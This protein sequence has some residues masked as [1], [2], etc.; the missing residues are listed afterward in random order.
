[1]NF[2][3]L[4]SHG[5]RSVAVFGETVLNRIVIAAFLLAAAGA[6]V[7]AAVLILKLLGFASP[8]WATTVA[9]VVI[10]IVAQIAMAGLLGLFVILRGQRVDQPDNQSVARSL[11]DRIERFGEA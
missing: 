7:L 10:I 11:I 5:L 4:T 8:G 1:M 2:I 3:D 9:G 6:L